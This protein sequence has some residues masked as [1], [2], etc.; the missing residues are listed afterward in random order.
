MTKLTLIPGCSYSLMQ[1][2][3]MSYFSKI[4]FVY[5]SVFQDSITISETVLL[6]QKNY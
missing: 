3:P 6:V 5:L 4:N 1:K 2:E